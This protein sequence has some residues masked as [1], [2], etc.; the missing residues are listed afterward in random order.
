[1][2]RPVLILCLTVSCAI[3]RV[4]GRDVAGIAIGHAKIERT[5]EGD[6][7]I[8][9]GAISRTLGELIGAAV[10]GVVVYFSGGAA[11]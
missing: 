9:G 4:D 6:A 3:G 7:R 1:M 5:A 10:A 11:L 8:Q 2:W